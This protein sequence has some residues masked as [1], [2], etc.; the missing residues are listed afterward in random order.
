MRRSSSSRCVRGV[1]IC[2][3]VVCVVAA[4]ES[5]NWA[6]EKTPGRGCNR[7]Q[8][9]RCRHHHRR[10]SRTAAQP[11]TAAVPALHTL[12]FPPSQSLHCTHYTSLLLS[13]CIAHTT[14]PSFTVSALCTL[15]F[16]PLQSLPKPR[17]L[18]ERGA[19]SKQIVS[20]IRNIN[21]I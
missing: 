16:P 9:H 19:F 14:T 5:M 13:P 20:C 8:Q 4:L 12:H 15:H 10:H 1:C 21:K 6:A 7:L 18:E 3:L 2:I 17:T 11:F